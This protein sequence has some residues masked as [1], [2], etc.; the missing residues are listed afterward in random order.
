[1]ADPVGRP[2]L[3]ALV[4]LLSGASTLAVAQAKPQLGTDENGFIEVL[5]PDAIPAIIQPRS[6]D[7]S[8]LSSSDGVLGVEV[9]GDARAYPLRILVWHEIVNDLVGGV[10]V[11]ATYCP[12]CGTGIA[13]DRRVAG[14]TLTFHVSGKL[15]NNDLVML[16]AETASLW[17][18]IIGSAA[19]GPMKGQALGV[20]PST[21]TTLGA[22]RAS[23]PGTQV[24]ARLRCDEGISTPCGAQPYQ[25]DY[26]AN[27]Y[28]GY[29]SNPG[30]LF[31]RPYGND[32]SALG[33]KE[34][35]LGV[36]VSQTAKAYPYKVLK[37][38]PVVND[39]VAGVAIVVTFADGAGHAF[40][41]D[42]R[43]FTPDSGGTIKDQNGAQW[44]MATG[45]GG[46]GSLRPVRAI[47]AFWFAWYDFYPYTQAYGFELGRGGGAGA[48]SWGSLGTGINP[49]WFMVALGSAAAL[50][51]AALVA[52]VRRNRKMRG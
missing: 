5:P 30:T 42:G 32:G 31:P 41:A 38:N 47:P 27:P 14:Q 43:K 6:E 51:G 33:P 46:T 45:V 8:W 17:P 52:Y 11:A 10:P 4:L 34:I 24:L 39:M 9:N 18:Q 35:V 49:L 40:E 28:G 7:A 20:I 3:I 1:M 16:D 36:L 21:T 13:Y 44:N 50:G 12:L 29:E 22:W 25:R 26:G 37:D 19:T 15:L 2:L 23:H 48:N